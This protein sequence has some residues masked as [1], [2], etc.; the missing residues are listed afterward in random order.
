[1]ATVVFHSSLLGM[2]SSPVHKGLGERP[3]PAQRSAVTVTGGESTTLH[4][5]PVKIDASREAACTVS[6]GGT[7]RMPLMTRQS[8]SFVFPAWSANFEKYNLPLTAAG[9][10][11]C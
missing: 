5:F 7:A 2:T 10:R 4:F 11:V 8:S 9:A 3:F 1:M 6:D